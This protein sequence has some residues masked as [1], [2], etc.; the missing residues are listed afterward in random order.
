MANVRTGRANDVDCVK[1]CTCYDTDS[2]RRRQRGGGAGARTPVG[3]SGPPT[4][5][6]EVILQETTATIVL[7]SAD[8]DIQAPS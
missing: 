5:I 1:A 4:R 6:H 2:Q 7:Q 3:N 8:A